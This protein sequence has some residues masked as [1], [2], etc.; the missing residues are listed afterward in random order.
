MNKK[1]P[2]AMAILFS[3]PNFQSEIHSD[4]QESHSVDE[5]TNRAVINETFS[6]NHENTAAEGCLLNVGQV[7]GYHGRILQHDIF[8]GQ[9]I[10]T[11]LSDLPSIEGIRLD[12]QKM[13]GEFHYHLMLVNTSVNSVHVQWHTDLGRVAPTSGTGILA[14]NQ[15]KDISGLAV[16][17][18]VK[19][20]PEVAQV[21]KIHLIIND[22]RWYKVDFFCISET[23]SV[24]LCKDYH[25]I[26]ISIERLQ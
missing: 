26:R 13:P 7:L 14:L 10:S 17:S 9:Y 21:Y 18:A 2:T 25:N 24:P 16:G 8:S 15:V 5:E 22:Q 3:K 4:I 20:Q 12:L 6:T 19:W 1:I 11:F 23:P